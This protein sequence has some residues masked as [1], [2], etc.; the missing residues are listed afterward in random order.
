MAP[1][2]ANHRRR[3]KYFSPIQLSVVQNDRPFGSVLPFAEA[4]GEPYHFHEA[5]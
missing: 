3:N 5:R 2:E 1:M 4:A